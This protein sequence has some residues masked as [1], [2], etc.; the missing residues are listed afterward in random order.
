M[1][2]ISAQLLALTGEA[3]VLVQ[4]GRI[5]FSNAAARSI[6]G[7]GCMGKSLEEVFGADIACAQAS[8]FVGNASVGGRQ[9]IVR[10]TKLEGAEAVFF[11]T[12]E[13]PPALLND[14]FIYSLRGSLMNFGIALELAR[15]SAEDAADHG[16]SEQLS[17]MAQ[18]YFK[19]R[20]AV[21]NASVIQSAA[22]GGAYCSME[23]L[24][25][26]DII[27]K[28]TDTLNLLSDGP[29]IVF[30]PCDSVVIPGDASLL[31]QLMLN[32]IS[33]CFVHAEGC[34]RI[35]LGVVESGERVMLSVTDDGRGVAP[36]D[37]HAV[38]DRFRH[39]YDVNTLGGGAGFGLT[40][41]RMI[42]QLHGGTVMLESR[43]GRGT[44]VRVSLSKTPPASCSF[45]AGHDGAEL[46]MSDVL[47][48]LA[49]CLPARCFSERYA[50]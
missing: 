43:E 20:R 47:T 25:I 12:A 46:R 11:T 36:D 15:Q 14:A 21:A 28:L 48:G 33:N 18:S 32:L 6:L 42:A 24:D 45:S 31:N 29:E 5:S 13:T 38:F 23:R 40:V 4:R 37:L 10:V 41:V 35:S 44:A 7:G 50:D 9:L 22:Q 39:G 30:S 19:V 8:A 1:H 17:S 16:L 2:H 3:A 26:C 34:T 27:Q 49:D